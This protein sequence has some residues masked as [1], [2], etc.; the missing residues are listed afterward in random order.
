MPIAKRAKANGYIIAC[1]F[2]LAI[3]TARA[4]V[5]Q[6]AGFATI[7]SFNGTDG[8][9]PV[10]GMILG[11]DGSLYGATSLGGAPGWAGTIFQLT[12]A[13]SAWTE[14]VLYSFPDVRRA[15]AEPSGGL[16]SDGNGALYATAV[17]GGM[18][19]GGGV[20]QLTPPTAP[21][22]TWTETTI[23]SFNA[24][25]PD[26]QNYP[27]G[28]LAAFPD[29]SLYGTVADGYYH[30]DVFVLRPPAAPGGR[31]GEQTLFTFSPSMGNAIFDGLISY[32][33][34]LYGAAYYS[35]PSST[36]NCGAVDE[37]TPPGAAGGAWTG[38]AI[39]TFEGAPTDGCHAEAVLAADA[40][41]T[42]YGTT[43]YGGSGACAA[44]GIE[45]GGC[46]T[47]FQLNPPATPGG[48][49]TETIIYNFAGGGRSDGAFPIGGVV[50]A[51]NRNLY[52]T[53]ST[54]GNSTGCGTV[55]QLTPPATAGGVWTEQ[56]LHR[57][58][59]QDSEGCYPFAQP[60][61]S[62]TG[63]LFG[64]TGW[65]GTTGQGTVFSVAP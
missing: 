44:I 55:F 3:L 65:G 34:S 63:A 26:N 16:V 33:G 53:T 28:P 31:W 4:D 48:P 47:V 11:N 43:E 61:L 21:G 19:G 40:N 9:Q 58:T 32:G 51:A 62:G 12:P 39:H 30:T 14:T 17:F 60:T 5:A 35:S 38:K 25:R 46:G 42:L 22:G 24:H 56:V 6:T 36:L 18:G 27:T 1:L 54:G 41:G 50:L 10:G 49:W 2:A 59:G 57:F 52:G 7:Y 45:P 15:F 29:G 37:I 64:T 8:Y 23:H 13:G 20:I